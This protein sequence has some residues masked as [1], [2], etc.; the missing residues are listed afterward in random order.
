MRIPATPP[1]FEKPLGAL[2]VFQDSPERL[3]KAILSSRKGSSERSYHHWD[4][5]RFRPIPQDWSAEEYWAITKMSRMPQIFVPLSPLPG[6]H[7]LH[8]NRANI[9]LE[10]LRTI[11]VK[12]AGAINSSE[13]PNA[14]GSG[15]RYLTRSLIEEP[16]SSSVLEGAATTRERARAMIDDNQQ[17]KSEGDI[18]VLNNYRAMQ[19]I[20]S[21]PSDELTPE[22]ILEFHRILTQDTL[23]RPEMAG[24]LRDNNDIVIGDDF[25]GDVFHDPPDFETLSERLDSLCKFANGHSEDMPYMHPITKAIILHFMLA[26][27]HPF[28]DGNGRT[29]R[30]LFYWSVLRDGYWLLEYASIS[31]ILRKA[32]AQYGRAFLLTETDDNDLTYF[33]LHQTEVIIRAL[34]ELDSYLERQKRKMLSAEALLK[35][36]TLN[37]RQKTLLVDF[38]KYRKTQITRNEHMRREDVSYLTASKDLDELWYKNWLVRR[39]QGR[40]AIHVAGPHLKK[41]IKRPDQK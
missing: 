30:A 11:D 37:R 12:A 18:M 26:Y 15:A 17:P 20:K 5:L 8:F 25:T 28:V 38:L 39:W 36:E 35:D 10:N 9:V 21:L 6:T 13:I 32:P 33:L 24:R 7:P 1:Q 22:I 40:T 14:P 16:F 2:T 3:G 34:D 29:A 23:K 27:D 19:H 31:H 4:D 41:L